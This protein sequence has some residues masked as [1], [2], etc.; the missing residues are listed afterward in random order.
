MALLGP[1]QALEQV[2]QIRQMDRLRQRVEVDW[3]VEPGV[4]HTYQM[5]VAEV[6]QVVDRTCPCH[7]LP[8][9]AVEEE[10]EVDR[11]WPWQ[12]VVVAVADPSFPSV[13]AE[14]EAGRSSSPACYRWGQEAEPGRRQRR[15]QKDFQDRQQA[16]L[17]RATQLGRPPQIGR[18]DCSWL[19]CTIRVSFVKRDR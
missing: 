8:A 7:P 14:V 11:T 17:L 18:K 13:V 16:V 19:L 10:P 15:M 1:E 4:G 12:A 6:E 3:Q 9:V 5:A 2:R